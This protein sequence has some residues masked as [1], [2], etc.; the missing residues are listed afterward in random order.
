MGKLYALIL[1]IVLGGH[2]LVGLFI[3]GDR[4]MGILNVDTLVDVIYLVSA[5]LL[6]LVAFT[7]SSPLMIRG[8]LFSVGGVLLLLGVLGLLDNRVFGLLPTG[9]TLV[10]FFLLFGAGGLTLIFSVLPS[11]PEP[12]TTANAPLN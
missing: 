8:V 5:A 11:T 2:G 4:L 9:L 7:R 6:F 10:D 1:G 3:E 12:L